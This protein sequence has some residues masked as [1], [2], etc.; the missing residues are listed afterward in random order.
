MRRSPHSRG[1]NTRSLWLIF[2]SSSPTPA[3]T[4]STI[5]GLFMNLL[6][7]KSLRDRAPHRAASRSCSSPPPHAH[8]VLPRLQAPAARVW[9]SRRGGEESDCPAPCMR[10]GALRSWKFNGSLKGASIAPA[11]E[12]T[13]VSLREPL[14]HVP[15]WPR[16]LR[17]ELGVRCSILR[18]CPLNVLARAK[19][20]WGDFRFAGKASAKLTQRLR[21]NRKQHRKK[22][23]HF[24]TSPCQGEWPRRGPARLFP[25]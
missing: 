3:E 11:N 8:T 18:R 4:A 15:W 1:S 25:P 23:P 17:Q 24:H 13:H 6:P 22:Y 5:K 19:R 10:T 2:R 20:R 7:R 12:L 16:R 21:A 9:P 14:G